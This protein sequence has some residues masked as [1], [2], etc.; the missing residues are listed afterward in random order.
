MEQGTG[1]IEEV[2]VA[3]AD[4]IFDADG[5]EIVG[6][7]RDLEDREAREIALDIVAGRVFGSW[8]VPEHDT[9]LLGAIFPPLIL[10]A[11]LPPNA[12]ALY[13]YLNNAGPRAI[14]GYPIFF[15]CRVLTVDDLGLV[16][17][18]VDTLKKQREEFLEES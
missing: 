6:P 7:Q 9:Q 12:G 16:Q 5:N 10:G 14:N 3:E 13:E 1:Q 15:S 4:K 17:K 18:H 8:A 11:R 2:E